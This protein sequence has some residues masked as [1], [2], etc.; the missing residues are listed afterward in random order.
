[1]SL[2]IQSTFKMFVLLI[3]VQLLQ[4]AIN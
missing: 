1:M 4:M 2:N 3:P